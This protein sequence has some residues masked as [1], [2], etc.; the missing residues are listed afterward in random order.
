MVRQWAVHQLRVSHRCSGRPVVDAVA[1]WTSMQWQVGRRCS[2]RQA[3]IEEIFVGLE[4]VI[5]W[6]FLHSFIHSSNESLS[7]SLS[8][9]SSGISHDSDDVI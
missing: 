8:L 6:R 4:I 1:G 9:H 3:S 7:F 2:G 5:K